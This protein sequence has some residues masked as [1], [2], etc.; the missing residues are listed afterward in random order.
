MGVEKKKAALLLAQLSLLVPWLCLGQTPSHLSPEDLAIE[1][2]SRNSDIDRTTKRISD[3]EQR[4]TAVRFHHKQTQANLTKLEEALTKQA[5]VFYKLSKNGGAIRFLF[6]AK[7]ATDFLKRMLLLKK[8]IVDA[9][10]ERRQT[11]VVLQRMQSEIQTLQ[12]DILSAKKMLQH[13]IQTRNELLNEQNH[14]R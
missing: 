8:I 11:G 14:Q 13:L 12:R 4:L 2:E 6:E 10:E 3:M 9:L 1:V 7:S 5:T